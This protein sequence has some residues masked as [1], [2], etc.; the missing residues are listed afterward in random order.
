M[1]V[2]TSQWDDARAV[3]HLCAAVE[4][5]NPGYTLGTLRCDG[6][7]TLAPAPGT[8]RYAWL[9]A[10]AGEVFLPAGYR[11][12]EGDGQPLQELYHADGLPPSDALALEALHQALTGGQVHPRLVPAIS[13]ICGR[14]KPDGFRGD[15]AGDIWTMLESQVP[16][17][18]WTEA[19]RAREALAWLVAHFHQLGWSTK[20]ESGW[21]RIL[22]GDLL[23][24]TAAD[25]LNLR[26][27]GILWWIDDADPLPGDESRVRR[28][29]YLRDTA[30]GCSPG[31]DAFRRLP[32]TWNAPPAVRTRVARDLTGSESQESRRN[33]RDT[34]WPNRMN[35]HVLHIE[36]AQSRTHYHPVVPI[37]G[38]APQSEFYF[39]LEAT[40]YDL[41]APPNAVPRLI[42]FPEI[43]N[44]S[45]FTATELAPGMAVFIPPGTGHRGIDAFVNVVTL[46]GFKPGNEIYVDGP[47]AQSGVAAP[48]NRSAA[49]AA[50]VVVNAS[51]L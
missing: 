46:P 40:A 21:E 1:T 32:L 25:P 42:T 22:P 20:R 18:E 34:D 36:E 44:W 7:L 13:G 49:E 10:G 41:H 37:G 9:A 17:R 5:H 16:P 31:F 43:G 3:A 51:R 24:S 39:A 33:A 29:R 23:I 26:G 4:Q 8:V 2:V 19:P 45:V 50:G 38:G 14:M 6:D 28:L 11:T 15:I 35:S 30:G 12:Q 48:F 27:A 47:I